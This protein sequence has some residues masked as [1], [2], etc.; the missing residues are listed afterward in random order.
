MSDE[1]DEAVPVTFI[2]GIVIERHYLSLVTCPDAIDPWEEDFAR[3]CY[4][5]ADER[6]EFDKW[7]RY[8]LDWHVFSTCV[9]SASPYT[10][11]AYVVLS[12][13]GDVRIEVAGGDPV[14]IE[15]IPDAGLHMDWSDN[16]GYVMTVRQIDQHLYVCGD[17]RQVYRRA[18]SGQWEHID[19]GILL[20]PTD[21]SMKCLMDIGGVS[22]RSIY[23]VGYSGEIFYFDGENWRQVNSGVDDD[24]F[25][26]KVVSELDIYIIGANGT[27][28]K[29]NQ[30]F[31]FKN[32]SSVE[33]NQRFT[34]I[35]IFNGTLFLA[36]NLGMFVYDSKGKKIVPYQTDL[37]PDLVDCHVLEAKDGVLWSIGFKDLACYDGKTWTRINHP[38]NPPI[39]AVPKAV[40]P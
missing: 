9:W 23:A 12:K 2:N 13:E 31:G 7:G 37:K 30:H 5:D 8:D 4:F 19:Q 21:K 10:K 3:V 20:P 38:D 28:L 33:D 11:R 15:H 18:D 27:L 14:I 17:N 24:L 26:V 16:Y 36:S 39:G 34:G 35:E 6:D 1:L 29:G 22:E 25:H 40:K 32:L